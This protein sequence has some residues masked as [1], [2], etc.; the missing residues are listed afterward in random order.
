MHRELPSRALPWRPRLV[1]ADPKGTPMHKLLKASIAGAAGIAL[2]AG[3]AGTFAAWQDSAKISSQT[4]SSGELRI[5]TATAPGAW[6][7]GSTAG[8]QIA[9]ITRYRIVPGTTLVF[10]QDLEIVATGDNL[11]AE[12]SFEGPVQRGALSDHITSKLDVTTT[13]AALTKLDADSYSVEAN[14]GTSVVTAVITVE[15]PA[16]DATADN[17]SGQ[18]QSVA[19]SD[20]KFTLTQQLS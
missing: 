5:D 15:Y 17:L 1:P 13:A 18:N 20:A 2:L 12:L 3:G 10:T 19:I 9:D 7:E 4:I 11:E 6:Y 14:S 8:D 16:E